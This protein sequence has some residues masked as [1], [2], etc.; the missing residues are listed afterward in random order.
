MRRTLVFTALFVAIAAG[1]AL[2][3]GAGSAGGDQ[4]A[5]PA[6]GA[7]EEA[8][9]LPLADMNLT[10]VYDN[11]PGPA[12]LRAEWGFA[13]LIEGAEKRILFDT[14]GEGAVLLANM[15]SL[16][17]D[18]GSVDLVVLSH[19][20]GDHTG[21]ARALLAANPGIPVFVP[22][23]FSEGLKQSLREAGGEVVDVEDPV[24]ICPGI[25]SVGQMG[26]FIREQGL[27]I[28]TDGGVIV[29]TGCAHPGIVSVIER[30]RE[31]TGCELLL[32][33][34]GFHL[35]RHSGEALG[36]VVAG[37]REA[38]V[39]YAGPC[40]CSGDGGRQAFAQAYGEAYIEL[41]VGSVV[42]GNDFR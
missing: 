42:R 40:H 14:G 4:E 1:S 7:V 34:G 12:G 13:C 5:M 8:T 32:A 28:V 36:E 9:M 16:A 3:V 26:E 17:I 21:G 22:A 6:P 31:I 19:F 20:H 35:G 24:E 2:W 37:F 38:G 27:A 15:E 33:M 29:V 11:N 30:A 41:N 18:P 39:R 10:V 23:A 25:L